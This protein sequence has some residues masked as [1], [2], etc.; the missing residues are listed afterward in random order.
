MRIG[1][2]PNN[3]QLTGENIAFH[4]VII[5]VYIPSETEYFKDSWQ[6]FEYC[7]F[8]LLKTSSTQLKISVVANGCCTEVNE[9]LFQLQKEGQIDE[10]VIE[11]EGIGKI[12]SVLKAVRTA[13]ERLI[14]I[15]DADVLFDEGWED[16]V[17]EVFKNFPRAGA[18]CPTPVFRKHFNLTGNIWMRYLFSKKLRFRPV[19]DPDAMTRFAKSIGWPWLDEKYKD[20]YATLQLKDGSSA[21]VGCS[22]FVATYKREVFE[23]MPKG[24]TNFKIRGDSELRYTDLPVLKRGGYRLSTINNYAFHMGNTPEDWMIEKF[25]ALATTEKLNDPPQLPLLNKP[26]IGGMSCEKVFKFFISF[27]PIQRRILLMKGL[28]REQAANFLGTK[29]A[30][31]QP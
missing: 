20:L 3:E 28:D 27:K 24:N 25:E 23:E 17:L 31:Q 7:L 10:L 30:S 11:T 6:V 14:T 21:M 5:P 12:N 4:R 29:T 19:Q 8:S 2:N 16:A 18:V 22:H 26:I 9:K 15:T 13:E 1:N